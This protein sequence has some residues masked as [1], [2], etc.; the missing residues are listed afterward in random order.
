MS[1]PCQNPRCTCSAADE[2]DFCSARCSAGAVGVNPPADCDCG[3]ETCQ[4]G[5]RPDAIDPTPRQ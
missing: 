4:S 1:R 3:H 5:G 2:S